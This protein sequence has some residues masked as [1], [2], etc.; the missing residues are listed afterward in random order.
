MPP[1][2]GNTQEIEALGDYLNA[3]VNPNAS[4]VA[5]AP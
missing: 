5:K 2:A 4:M 1:L 3:F